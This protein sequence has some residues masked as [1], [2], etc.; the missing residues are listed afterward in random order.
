MHGRIYQT[1]LKKLNQ[2]ITK[3]KKKGGKRNR[4]FRCPTKKGSW[5]AG[6]GRW[7]SDELV[8]MVSL[9]CSGIGGEGMREEKFL[10]L[11]FFHIFFSWGS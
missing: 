4:Y 2:L 6:I 7:R 11:I 1:A 5:L 10:F 3:G 9:V 8:Q